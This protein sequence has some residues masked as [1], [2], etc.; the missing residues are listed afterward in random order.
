M[1]G[2][3]KTAHRAKGCAGNRFGIKKHITQLE[4]RLLQW[5]IWSQWKPKFLFSNA[6]PINSSRMKGHSWE[7]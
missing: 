1:C 5:K 2:I 6:V 3:K 7:S 4:K